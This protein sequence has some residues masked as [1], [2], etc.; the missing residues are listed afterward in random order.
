MSAVTPAD[1]DCLFADPFAQHVR[2]PGHSGIADW[3]NGAWANSTGHEPLANAPPSNS[4]GCLFSDVQRPTAAQQPDDDQIDPIFRGL[5]RTANDLTAASNREIS[6]LDRTPMNAGQ[7]G[8]AGSSS[9]IMGFSEF[10]GMLETQPGTPLQRLASQW[11]SSTHTVSEQF[12]LGSYLLHTNGRS[13]QQQS[14]GGF[15]PTEGHHRAGSMPLQRRMQTPESRLSSCHAGAVGLLHEPNQAGL[16]PSNAQ[17]SQQHKLSEMH[18]DSRPADAEVDRIERQT[19]AQQVHSEPQQHAMQAYLRGR[20]AVEQHPSPTCTR[21][22]NSTGVIQ[23]AQQLQARQ[24]A[25]GAEPSR[26]ADFAC[27]R[28]NA[29][30]TRNAECPDAG[31]ESSAKLINSMYGLAPSSN[32]QPSHAWSTAFQ[33]EDAEPARTTLDP[34]FAQMHGGPAAYAAAVNFREQAA[35][36]GEQDLGTALN[37]AVICQQEQCLLSLLHSLATPAAIDAS[38]PLLDKGA[39]LRNINSMRGDVGR[40]PEYHAMHGQHIQ[41]RLASVLSNGNVD[42]V[43]GGSHGQ[44]TWPLGLGEA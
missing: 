13:L 27:S 24:S 43:V 6:Q 4:D 31:S 25:C 35:R 37:R 3:A 7:A 1:L 34:G 26:A 20:A 12:D 16:T 18:Q 11:C 22:H 19:S 17:P 33:T 10:A 9:P 14:D 30:D 36:G 15:S 21:A 39:T 23:A 44:T 5:P 41:V 42:F 29:N 8:S 28:R 2:L 40:T 32:A 38:G